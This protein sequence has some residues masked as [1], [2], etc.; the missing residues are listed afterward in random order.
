MPTG[1]TATHT[2]VGLVAVVLW[3]ASVGLVRHVSELLG[4]TAGAATIFTV[5]GLFSVIALGIPRLRSLNPVYLYG[6]GFLFVAYEICFALSLGLARDRSQALELAMINYLWPCL[7]IVLAVIFRQHR[8]SWLLAPGVALCLGGV[9]WLMTGQAG[10]SAAA[11]GRNMRLNPLAYALAGGAAITWAGY[12]V[13]TRQYG[14]GRS[15]VSLFLLVTGAVLWARYGFV[16]E[17]QMRVTL[18]GTFLVL[19]LGAF[20]AAAYSCWNIGVQRGNLAVLAALSYFTPVFSTLLASLW[21]GVRPGPAF[22]QGVAMVTAGSLLC[23][24]ST[25][26]GPA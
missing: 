20:S 1:S 24:W 2:L 17:P 10:W 3:S 7:T 8:G 11:L 5:S 23:W 15:G 25:R 4:P 12:S 14:G 6:G 16:A 22:W 9:I 13:V 21:L 19:V 26:R 18:L